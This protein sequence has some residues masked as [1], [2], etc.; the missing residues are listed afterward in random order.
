[1][2]KRDYGSILFWVV[3]CDLALYDLRSL[4]APWNRTAQ[5]VLSRPRTSIASFV[6]SNLC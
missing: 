5:K 4:V 2:D 3:A 6:L 1:M